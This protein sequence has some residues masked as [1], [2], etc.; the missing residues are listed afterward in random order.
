MGE[1]P[2]PVAFI[3]AAI[4]RY[5][6]YLRH[7]FPIPCMDESS[8][9]AYIHTP[10]NFNEVGDTRLFQLP[11]VTGLCTMVP[12]GKL[13]KELNSQKHSGNS[14]KQL[15]DWMSDTLLAIWSCKSSLPLVRA[16]LLAALCYQYEGEFSSALQCFEKA[17]SMFHGLIL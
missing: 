11:Y 10:K 3:K 14:I 2:L 6:D 13:L 8:V 16:L 9:E 12:L 5:E 7:I 1:E 17:K 15:K 4:D